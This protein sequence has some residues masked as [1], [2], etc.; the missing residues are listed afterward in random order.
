MK[1][2]LFTL[3]ALAIGTVAA[4]AADLPAKAYTKAP[5]PVVPVYSWTGFYVGG[6]VG[7]GWGNGDTSFN[8]LPTAA[9][10]GS[11]APTTL[12]PNPKGVLGGAQIGYNWQTGAW[13]WG[14]EA[15]IQGADINGSAAQS[16]IIQ[17]NGTSFGA[18]SALSTSEKI[19]WFG[20]VRGRV[21]FAAA[22]QVLLY[23]TGGLAYGDVKYTANSNFLPAG[24]QIYPASISDTRVGWTA[25]G[26][27]EW[28]FAGAW[29]AKFEGLYYDLGTVST[30]ANGIPG[31]P[32][33]ACGGTGLCQVGY[34]WKTT[35]AI[36]RVGINYRFGGPV[37]ARY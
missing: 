13:V 21:G 9:G 23:T 11:L 25:G 30:T 3:S 6:N 7:Y 5:P 31:L 15:D 29:S 27:V 34:S 32:A 36:A 1:R 18:G 17:F 2:L 4:S 8:P 24:N 19:D 35:G 12:G 26:G 14:I 10:F 28:A 20:T 16:P 37:V 33:G 22:P